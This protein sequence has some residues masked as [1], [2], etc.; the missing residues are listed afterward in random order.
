MRRLLVS[1]SFIRNRAHHETTAGYR[2]HFAY[3]FQNLIK[4]YRSLPI[5]G[6]RTSRL[7]FATIFC[8]LFDVKF[9]AIAIHDLDVGSVVDGELSVGTMLKVNFLVV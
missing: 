4:C 1:R 7:C 9:C 6:I 5:I 8:F 2:H 3:R